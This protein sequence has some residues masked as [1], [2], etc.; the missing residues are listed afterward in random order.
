M[1]QKLLILLFLFL[2]SACGNFSGPS[3]KGMTDDQIAKMWFDQGMLDYEG[4]KLKSAIKKLKKS[5]AY[6]P[7]DTTAYNIASS[8]S[9]G[10]KID[11][12]LTYMEKAYELGWY[13]FAEEQH[14][15]NLR[16]TDRYKKLQK[17]VENDLKTF[18]SAPLE[19]LLRRPAKER[20][21]DPG[22]LVVLHHYGSSPSGF[23]ELYTDLADEQNLLIMACRGTE[24]SGKDKYYWNHSEQ[25][26]KRLLKE[27]KQVIK[28]NRLDRSR[29][30]LSG[31]A[32]GATQCLKF[33]IEQSQLFSGL[34]PISAEFDSDR[35]ALD[36]LRNKNLRVYSLAPKTDSN[37][38]KEL[39]LENYCAA[40]GISLQT[41]EMQ[42]SQ[43][44]PADPVRVLGEAIRWISE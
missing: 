31:F 30:F 6:R 35:V 40:Q 37:E 42:Q 16:D 38:Q 32:D 12:A 44:F 28:A 15:Q 41:N 13:N 5:L 29:I 2:L 4:M 1:T 19:P 33:G 20:K 22:L 21:K 9:L 23:A 18:K 26:S 17:T 34:I 3:T 25:E 43:N 8:Y 27:V 11:S 7:L 39:A 14:L 10:G 24:A 36:Q